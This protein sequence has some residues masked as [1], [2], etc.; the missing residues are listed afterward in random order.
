MFS[1]PVPAKKKKKRSVRFLLRYAARANP[2]KI[3]VSHSRA[4]VMVCAERHPSIPLRDF[5]TGDTPEK[6]DLHDGGYLRRK[7]PGNYAGFEIYSGTD[8]IS[9][10]IVSY[11]QCS[12]TT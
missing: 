7:R 10:H 9:Y 1:E 11:T 3:M 5:P 6:Q 12:G 4:V 2:A 8:I